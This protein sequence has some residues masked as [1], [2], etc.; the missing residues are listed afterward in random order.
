MGFGLPGENAHAPDESMSLENFEKGTHAA[1]ALLTEL[2]AR[3][4]AGTRPGVHRPGARSG[5]PVGSGF[6]AAHTGRP[7]HSGR[8][9]PGPGRSSPLGQD[10]PADADDL[11][12][13]AVAVGVKVP[14]TQPL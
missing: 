5:R 11:I 1:A 8:T 9:A 6:A 14:W 4:A 7:V 3:V 12:R 10:L 13:V 2:G